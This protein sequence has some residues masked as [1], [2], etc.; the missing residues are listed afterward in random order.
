MLSIASGMA[1]LLAE[2]HQIE[3]LTWLRALMVALG[4]VAVVALCVDL[5]MAGKL[6]RARKVSATTSV[7]HAAPRTG[8]P[9]NVPPTVLAQ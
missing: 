2:A 1:F 6:R 8:L 7:A 9:P 3:G 5:V 4:F